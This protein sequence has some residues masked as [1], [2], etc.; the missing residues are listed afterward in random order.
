MV[1]VFVDVFSTYYNAAQ[2]GAADVVVDVDVVVHVAVIPL[3]SKSVLNAQA[4]RECCRY[5]TRPGYN[6]YPKLISARFV[7]DLTWAV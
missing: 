7:V 2:E 1:N 3:N 6:F 4:R 5:P